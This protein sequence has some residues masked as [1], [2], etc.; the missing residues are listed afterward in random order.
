MNDAI[1]GL[2]PE[3]D[4]S[5]Y[6]TKTEL[7]NCGYITSIPSQYVTEN[8]LNQALDSYVTSD[9]LSECGYATTGYVADYVQGI[10]S[11]DIPPIDLSAYVTK[12]EL[13]N[14]G[15]ITSIPD[16]YAT[17]TYVASYVNEA[18]AD[19]QPVDLSTYVTKTELSNCGYLTSIPDTYATKTYVTN[20]IEGIEPVSYEVTYEVSYNTTTSISIW[21]GTYAQYQALP[22][23][24]TYQLYLIQ[25]Y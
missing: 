6:V 19:I 9:E 20:A 13:S 15:Y 21:Q 5:A 17:K 2:Q 4:L 16:T 24:Y 8:E 25:Q 12:T 14:C 11:G 7:S 18:I 10:I 1:S 3:I 23:H 22:D